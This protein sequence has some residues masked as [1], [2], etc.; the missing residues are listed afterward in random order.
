MNKR[1]L[2]IVLCVVLAMSSV[3]AVS[4]APAAKAD[5]KAYEKTIVAGEGDNEVTFVFKEVAKNDRFV[6][7]FDEA[8]TFISLTD[9]KTG[10]TWYSNP[11]IS[12]NE[13]PYVE[14]MAKTDI[15]S[16]LR[17]AYTNSSMKTKDANSYAGSVMRGAFE[18]KMLDNGLRVDYTFEEANI[19]IPVQYT[20]LDDGMKAEVIFSEIKENGSNTLNTLDFLMYFGASGEKDK[21]YFV[22]PDGSGA[23]INFNNEKNVDS[24]KYN[25]PFYGIDNA[26][27]TEA[28]IESSRSE[29]ITLPVFGVVKNGYGFLAEVVSGAETANLKAAMSGNRLVGAYNVIYTGTAS[30]L[31]GPGFQR[32]LQRDVQRRGY[33]LA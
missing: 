21:G 11:P 23:L 7:A 30:A 19:V 24:M 5:Q 16:V 32:D 4:A 15:R 9:N 14:G 3:L 18:Y 28:D 13:D 2:A 1:L 10:Q 27:T 29:K 20:L 31:D 12:V 6:L 26:E 17:I 33:L 25:K 8:S 22:V